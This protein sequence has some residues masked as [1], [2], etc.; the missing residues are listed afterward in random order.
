MG[1]CNTF[2]KNALRIGTIV[3]LA[4]GATALIAGP[5]RVGAVFQQ[6][7]T[8]VNAAIDQNVEDPIAMRAQL[9]DLEGQYPER[10]AMVREDLA[11][12]ETQ[13]AQLSRELTVSQKVVELAEGDLSVLDGTIARATNIR[14]EN[15]G[16][17]VRVSF[18]NS[19]YNLPDAQAKATQIRQVRNV[20][21]TRVSNVQRDLNLLGTQHQRLTELANRLETERAEFQSQLM[22]LDRTIDQIARNDRMIEMMDERRQTIEELDRYSAH[23]LD[24]LTT[25]FSSILQRQEAELQSLANMEQTKSYEEIAEYMV[26]TTGQADHGVGN[27]LSSQS[28]VVQPEVIEVGPEGAPKALTGAAAPITVSPEG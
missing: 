9:R 28:F 27:G 13:V 25:R 1:C 17:L 5:E 16:R 18:E 15:P 21:A 3:A 22:D 6:A 23:S 8:T 4:G 14:M 11:E 26:D 20:H 2:G 12:L 24:Q 19:T 10:I 7:K